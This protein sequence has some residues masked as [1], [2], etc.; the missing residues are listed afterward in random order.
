YLGLTHAYG[1]LGSWPSL[2]T[3]VPAVLRQARGSDDVGRALA[4]HI[5]AERALLYPSTLHAFIDLIAMLARDDV[6][7]VLDAGTYPVAAWAVERAVACGA[8]ACVAHDVAAAVDR[9][10]R[11]P[12]VVMDGFRPGHDR[13]PSLRRRLESVRNR[14]G[15]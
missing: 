7:I 10:P 1:S 6:E 9:V 5:G 13:Q 11:R 8:S 15:L 3:G 2:T 12:V 14:G 4:A